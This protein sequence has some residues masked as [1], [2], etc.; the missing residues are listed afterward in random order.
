[1]PARRISGMVK[2]PEAVTLATALPEIVPIRPEPTMAIL[3]LPPSR[4]PT[5]RTARSMK[6][7]APPMAA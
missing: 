2:T 4:W 3:A 1:M 5:R 6:S 7:W